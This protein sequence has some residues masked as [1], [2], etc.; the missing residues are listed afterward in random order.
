[1]E[2]IT[3][4]QFNQT[5]TVSDLVEALETLG[6]SVLI[7]K[8]PALT[9]EQRQHATKKIFSEPD[10]LRQIDKAKEHMDA[11]DM[12]YFSGDEEQFAKLVDEVNGR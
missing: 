5:I 9:P 7:E 10:V 1:V 4:D 2:F 11:G 3:R 6:Y 8:R 12:D